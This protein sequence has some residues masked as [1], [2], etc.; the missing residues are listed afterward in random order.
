MNNK[1]LKSDNIISNYMISVLLQFWII[2]KKHDCIFK[3][4]NFYRHVH[5]F[6]NTATPGG[7]NDTYYKVKALHTAVV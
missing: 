6:M 1:L 2:Y 3:N 7:D 5:D 4:F